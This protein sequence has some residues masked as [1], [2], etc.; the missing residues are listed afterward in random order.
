MLIVVFFFFYQET[1]INI[2]GSCN[3]L[4]H[5][6]NLM[7]IDTTTKDETREIINRYLSEIRAQSSS[8]R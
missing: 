6:G 7:I 2:G 1:A 3:L 4:K 5:N 8:G